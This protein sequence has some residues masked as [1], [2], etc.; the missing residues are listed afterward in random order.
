MQEVKQLADLCDMAEEIGYQKAVNALLYYKE[1]SED[2]RSCLHN[3][4]WAYWLN[5]QME[6]VLKK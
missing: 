6:K 1:D 5:S 4:E 2:V 3:K